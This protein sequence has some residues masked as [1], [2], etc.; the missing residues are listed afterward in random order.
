MER[1]RVTS[2]RP[3]HQ[4]QDKNMVEAIFLVSLLLHFKQVRI[5]A[6]HLAPEKFTT[7]RDHA[8]YNY[9]KALNYCLLPMPARQTLQRKPRSRKFG[10]ESKQTCIHLKQPD[11]VS[12]DYFVGSWSTRNWLNVKCDFFASSTIHTIQVGIT[13]LRFKLHSCAKG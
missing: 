9:C 5:T 13:L 11:P 12:A 8:R 1:T 10:K 7:S 3:N 6:S 4:L 2:R